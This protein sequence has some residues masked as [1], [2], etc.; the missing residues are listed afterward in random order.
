MQTHRFVYRLPVVQG[1]SYFFLLP[2]LLALDNLGEE[3][4]VKADN[5][6]VLD[7]IHS[8]AYDSAWKFRIRTLQG[9]ILMGGILEMIVGLSGVIGYLIKFITPLTIAPIIIQLGIAIM[10]VAG[11]KINQNIYV[12]IL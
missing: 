2:T 6:T 4:P 3:C 1:T 7:F 8:E 12:S 5:Q 10:P 11:E 9:A